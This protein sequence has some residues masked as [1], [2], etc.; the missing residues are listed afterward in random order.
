[1]KKEKRRGRLKSV[2]ETDNSL[3]RICENKECNKRYIP[4]ARYQRYCIK[5]QKISHKKG[6]EKMKSKYKSAGMKK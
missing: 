1:M 2:Y 3:G 5:C 4:H 6:V